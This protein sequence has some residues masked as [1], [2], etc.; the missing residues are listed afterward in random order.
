M[1]ARREVTRTGDRGRR[2]PHDLGANEAVGQPRR[3]AP[4]RRRR[5]VRGGTAARAGAPA[6]CAAAGGAARARAR[7]RV[8]VG[9]G[10]LARRLHAGGGQGVAGGGR[11]ARDRRGGARDDGG[12]AEGGDR[13]P[14]LVGHVH[15]DGGGRDPRAARHAAGHGRRVPVRHLDLLLRARREAGDAA[16]QL[17]PALGRGE[18]EVDQAAAGP[19]PQVVRRQPADPQHGD[20]RPLREPEDQPARRLPAVARADPRLPRRLLLRH[21]DREG[22][23]LPGGKDA[24]AARNSSAGARNSARNS[25]TPPPLRRRASFG[26]RTSRVRS[27]TAARASRGSP[28]AG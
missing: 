27:P 9:P 18:H 16:A 15:Q 13:R 7:R 26:S 25:P 11:A 4:R 17:E 24:A 8:R 6:A 12:G 28:R 23:N 19:D 2:A 5:R 3:A 22:P 10:R 21:V 20:R 14:R 1:R